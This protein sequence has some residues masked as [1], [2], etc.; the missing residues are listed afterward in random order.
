MLDTSTFTFEVPDADLDHLRRRLAE[1]TLPAQTAGPDWSRGIPMALVEDLLTYWLDGFDWRAHERAINREQHR[2]YRDPSGDLI[3]FIQRPGDTNAVPVLVLHGWPYTYAQMIPLIDAIDGV[4]TMIAPS[5][6]GFGHSPASNDLF[7]ARGI[8]QAM[9]RLMT[10][11]LGHERYMV[12]GE[13]IGAPI[14][15]WMAALHPE[16]VTGI[17][18]SH[19][20]F[21]AQARPGKALTAEEQTFLDSTRDPLESGYAHLQGT[22]PDTLATALTDSPVGLLAWIAE[23]VACW[24]DGGGRTGIG[25]IA[26]DDLLALVATYWHTKSI[27][28]SFRSYS[29]PDDFDDHPVITAPATI[30]INTHEAAYPRSLAEKSYSDIRH[31]ERLSYGGHFTAWEAPQTVASAII[32][33]AEYI[34]ETE[35]DEDPGLSRGADRF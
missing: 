1:A 24:S 16:S 9:H 11:G 5:L 12:Y 18:A 17:V 13:D 3:H 22:R 15:D 27:G 2:F 6:P 21:S 10:A 19:P 28:T 14:A 20:S 26:Q 7:S 4:H 34:A 32:R 30:L 33:H 35:D 8:A 29:E 31:F 25:P 23:K